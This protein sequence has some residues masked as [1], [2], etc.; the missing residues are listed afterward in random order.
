VAPAPARG[1]R[2]WVALAVTLFI[3]F[4]GVVPAGAQMASPALE[5]YVRV[6]WAVD[7]PKSGRLRVTGYAYNSRD[8]AAANVKLLV[9]ALDSSGH[10]VDSTL[11]T[12]YGEVPSRNRSYFEVRVPPGG[13]SYRVSVSSVD[14]RSCGGGGS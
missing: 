8:M 12:V 6:E 10:V 5:S 7:Q 9:E 1:E 3:A 14:W 11:A 2:A 13:A 4:A